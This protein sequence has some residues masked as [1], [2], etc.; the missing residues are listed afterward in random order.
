MFDDAVAGLGSG[1]GAVSSLGASLVD[2]DSS[3]TRSLTSLGFGAAEAAAPE[4]GAAAG[5]ATGD[6]VAVGAGRLRERVAMRR[7]SNRDV[8]VLKKIDDGTVCYRALL[9]R[10]AHFI[11]R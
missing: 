4:T 10:H 3:L 8:P 11:E 7:G 6:P 2:A 1:L 9:P 5:T